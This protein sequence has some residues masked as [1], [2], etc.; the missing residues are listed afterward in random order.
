MGMWIVSGTTLSCG[1]LS[2]IT[3]FF[4]PQRW[5]KYSVW[6]GKLKLA[7]SFKIFLLI[8][9]VHKP[10]ILPSFAKLVAVL[11]AFITPRA[12]PGSPLPGSAGFLKSI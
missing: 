4:T 5:A 9:A 10:E 1:Q 6:P 3:A 8:G 11:I 2:I 12:F 7:P